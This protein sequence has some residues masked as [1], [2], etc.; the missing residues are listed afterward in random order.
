MIYTSYFANWRNYPKGF[1]KIRIALWEPKYKVEIDGVA[2]ELAPTK[3]MLLSRKSG[4]MDDA[5]YTKEFNIKL[6]GLNPIDIANKYDNCILLC[7]EKTGDFCHRN[8][9][10]EWLNCNGV[11]CEELSNRSSKR[12]RD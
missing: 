4:L 9:V 7:Y 1:K 5:E 10:R 2:L 8:L 12:N 11:Q 6:T 3:G